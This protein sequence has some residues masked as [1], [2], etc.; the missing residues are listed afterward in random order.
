[1]HGCNLTF[2]PWK[3]SDQEPQ[4][5]TIKHTFC[6]SKNLIAVANAS[7]GDIPLVCV[8]SRPAFLLFQESLVPPTPP[9]L[10]PSPLLSPSLSTANTMVLP[11]PIP[12][13]WLS[14]RKVGMEV[15]NATHLQ[16]HSHLKRLWR[17]IP[18]PSR[19][20]RALLPLSCPPRGR[21]C[22]QCTRWLYAS[23]S[24]TTDSGSAQPL[25]QSWKT[26]DAK[27]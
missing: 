10:P 2:D 5:E 21:S 25:R 26:Q 18:S 16:E 8:Y 17:S 19:P 7:T 3:S 14:Y 20:R 6:R 12:S 15:R 9:P 13:F 22:W 27:G 24:S 11:L 23:C 1:M 4:K